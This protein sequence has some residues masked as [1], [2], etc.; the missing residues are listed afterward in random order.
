M[1]LTLELIFPMLGRLAVLSK[2][3]INSAILVRVCFFPLSS[4]SSASMTNS[5]SLNKVAL[6]LKRVEGVP[7]SWKSDFL[8]SETPILSSSVVKLSLTESEMFWR[9]PNT[10][11]YVYEAASGAVPKAFTTLVKL[12]LTESEMFWIPPNTDVYV[13]E[14]LSGKGPR[15]IATL[16][17]LFFTASEMFWRPPNTSVYV[18]EVSSGKGPRAVATLFES[19]SSSFL[20]VTFTK[21]PVMP[22]SVL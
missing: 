12:S 19:V 6:L 18:Y 13:Y 1:E 2:F 20:V 16:V 11:V 4:K 3:V 5:I 10:D 15:A 22:S 9:P 7:I 21:R 14:V 17:K 8:F